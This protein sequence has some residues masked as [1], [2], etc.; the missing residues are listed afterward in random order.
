MPKLIVIINGE[1]GAR[2]TVEVAPKKQNRVTQRATRCAIID[3][4][5]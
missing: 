3:V 5:G 2:M 1:D 4:D